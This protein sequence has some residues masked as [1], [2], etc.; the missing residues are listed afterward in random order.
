MIHGTVGK[1][2]LYITGKGDKTMM[3]FI[4]TFLSIC[5]GISIIGGA[6]A[7]I[8]KMFHPAFKLKDR[9]DKLEEN[10]QKDFKA[11]TEMKDMQAILCQGMIAMID[12]AI[13]GN[14][15]EGLKKTKE[16]MI[17]QLSKGI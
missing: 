17:Q 12:N 2:Y 13:T 10:A 5:G 9:V 15:I 3:Q 16:T 7:V 6:A 4:Q 1:K 8:Y 11:I 14:N